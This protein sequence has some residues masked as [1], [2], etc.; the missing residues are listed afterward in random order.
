MTPGGLNEGVVKE[1]ASKDVYTNIADSMDT[2]M[3]R[4]LKK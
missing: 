2:A 4:L 3:D 1:L